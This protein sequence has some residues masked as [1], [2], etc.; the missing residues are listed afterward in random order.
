ML[1]AGYLIENRSDRRDFHQFSSLRQ[2]RCFLQFAC[3]FLLLIPAALKRGKPSSNLQ[4][5]ADRL[6]RFV[7]C[8]SAL[9]VAMRYAIS[10]SRPSAGS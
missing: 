8:C 9:P 2:R 1:I 5:G 10:F 4:G 6:R 3:D 7:I